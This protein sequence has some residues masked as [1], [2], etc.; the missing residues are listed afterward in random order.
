M[1]PSYKELAAQMAKAIGRGSVALILIIPDISKQ[2]SLVEPNC[3]CIELN[4]NPSMY[5]HIKM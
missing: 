3:S 4:F 5:M 2:A 1:D